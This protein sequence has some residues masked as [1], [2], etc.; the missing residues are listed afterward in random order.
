MEQED[1]ILVQVIGADIFC[2]IDND[3]DSIETLKLN[4]SAQNIVKADINSESIKYLIETTGQ[5]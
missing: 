3:T 5:S 4:D 1:L 2:S